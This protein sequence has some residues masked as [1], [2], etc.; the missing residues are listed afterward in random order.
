M[1]HTVTITRLPDETSDDVE[2]TVG[3]EH[4]STCE[5]WWEC[6]S[7]N[8]RHPKNENYDLYEWST[9]RTPEEHRFIDGMWMV[10]AGC[11]FDT[12]LADNGAEIDQRF[13]R[14][15]LGT[16]ELLIEFDDWWDARV[17]QWLSDDA[18]PGGA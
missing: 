17:G 16:F 8:H 4:D 11:G 12:A 14:A 15:G 18:H 3:G 9:K 13:I 10:Q 2:Y 5:A 7:I 6:Q 1:S